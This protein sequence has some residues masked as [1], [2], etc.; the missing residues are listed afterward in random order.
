MQVFCFRCQKELI[1]L[2]GL[3]FSP[4]NKENLVNKI[5]LCTKCYNLTLKFLHYNTKNQ[6]CSCDAAFDERVF[7][8]DKKFR[9][10]RKKKKEE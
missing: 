5:H 8:E 9:N 10:I 3:L 7:Q 6:N 2:G 4:P 1:E